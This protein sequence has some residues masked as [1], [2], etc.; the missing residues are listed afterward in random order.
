MFTIY[1]I[2]EISGEYEDYRDTI[3]GSYLHKERA[4]RELKKFKNALNERRIYYHKC[5]DCPAQ[6][7]CLSDE[8][9]KIRENYDC[10]A[11][12]FDDESLIEFCKNAVYSCDENASYDIEEAD[13]DDEED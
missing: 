4:E 12:E 1:Q 5:S 3:V 7:G 8:I 2:H 9:D 11:A 6:F 13:V 10:F